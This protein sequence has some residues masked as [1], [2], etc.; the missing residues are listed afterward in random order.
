MLNKKET[1][2]ILKKTNSLLDGHFI[3]SSGLRSE[4]Y[5][6]CAQL[7]MHPNLAEKVCNSLAEKIN[8]KKIDFDL[9]ASPAIGGI[10]VGYQVAKLLNIPNIFVERV[11]NKFHLRR[12]FDCKNKK[13]LIVEDVITTGKSSIECANCLENIGGKIMGYA[14][15]VDRSEGKSKISNI[16]SQINF[17][18]PT[19]SENNLPDH[20]KKIEAIKPGSRKI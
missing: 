20:L 8:S 2:E 16:I 6:Q 13:I 11:N 14:C 4:K 3:L 9:I 1:I 5:L 17:N 18:I 10:L 12:G 7:M 15:I 19:F